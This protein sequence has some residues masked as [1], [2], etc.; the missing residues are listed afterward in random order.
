MPQLKLFGRRWHVASGKFGKASD[1]G[2][3]GDPSRSFP[4]NPP[5][6]PHSPGADTFPLFAVV[7]AFFHLLWFLLVMG[8]VVK[9]RLTG[10]DYACNASDFLRWA[11]YGL[12]LVFLVSLLVEVSLIVVGLR[13]MC[14]AC[15]DQGRGE[16]A[17][18]PLAPGP[19]RWRG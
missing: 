4:P 19:M 8:G 13:G 12:F 3:L 18:A 1:P 10:L 6:T 15:W 9:L 17:E 7:S 2:A 14:V 5:H 11:L 16:G